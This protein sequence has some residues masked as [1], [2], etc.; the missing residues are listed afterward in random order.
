MIASAI[1]LSN[2]QVASA[3]YDPFDIT[4]TNYAMSK[5]EKKTNWPHWYNKCFEPN[6]KWTCSLSLQ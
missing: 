6:K 5:I 2:G 3:G 4:L 1:L